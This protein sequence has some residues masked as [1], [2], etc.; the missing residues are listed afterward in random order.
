MGKEPV[1][2]AFKIGSGTGKPAE[3]TAPAGGE[4]KAFQQ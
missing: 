3:T 4:G 2:M 1:L